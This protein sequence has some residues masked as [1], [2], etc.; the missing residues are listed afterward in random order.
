VVPFR[1]EV[2][3]TV[4]QQFAAFAAMGSGV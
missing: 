1:R 4:A 2:Y 3:R